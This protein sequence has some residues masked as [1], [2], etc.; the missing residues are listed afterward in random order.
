M[1]IPLSQLPSCVKRGH[2]GNEKVLSCRYREGACHYPRIFGLSQELYDQGI[3]L[4]YFT[5]FRCKSCE[6]PENCPIGDISEPE[7][8]AMHT[9]HPPN[10]IQLQASL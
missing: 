9:Y 2:T 4:G 1:E 7:Q 10:A 3:G 8:E 6:G 5:D